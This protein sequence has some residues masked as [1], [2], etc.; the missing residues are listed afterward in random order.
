[1]INNYF[2]DVG[3]SSTTSIIRVHAFGSSKTTQRVNKPARSRAASQRAYIRS[4]RHPWIPT[5]FIQARRE[6][7]SYSNAL[8]CASR[9]LA[10]DSE[11]LESERTRSAW[12][13]DVRNERTSGRRVNSGVEQRR[14]GRRSPFPICLFDLVDRRDEN[15]REKGREANMKASSKIEKLA[16]LVVNEKTEI[17]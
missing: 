14:P 8:A 10:K 5:S 2:S 4:S 12:G 6:T 9:T 3:S 11:P 1:M 16:S 15:A 13:P 7:P 17:C